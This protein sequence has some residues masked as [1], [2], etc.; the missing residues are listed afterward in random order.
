MA[1]I[2][3]KVKDVSSPG[4]PIEALASDKKFK[5]IFLD[6][7]LMNR[8]IGLEYNEAFIHSNLLAIYKGQLAEQFVGQEFLAKNK[9]QLY[10][11]ARE[12]KNSIAEIDFLDVREGKFIP[13]EI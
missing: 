1:R 9:K 7:G 6:I 12:A 3:S 10:Y 13:V 5:S 4:L 8:S 2:A 11:W